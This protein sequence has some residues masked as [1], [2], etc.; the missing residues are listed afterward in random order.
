MTKYQ[1]FTKLSQISHIRKNRNFK[2]QL[3]RDG[4]T[5]SSLPILWQ[6]HVRNLFLKKF[7]PLW[8][9]KLPEVKKGFFTIVTKCM[10]L[11]SWNTVDC[12]V[13]EIDG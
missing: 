3:E 4:P 8:A 11:E 1:I 10:L 7:C 13:P 6:G 2:V 9:V 12:K 5:A